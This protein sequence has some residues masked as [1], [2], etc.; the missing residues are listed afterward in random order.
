MRRKSLGDCEKS[1]IF[2][3]DLCRKG[4]DKWVQSGAPPPDG[5]LNNSKTKCT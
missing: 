1:R 2:A 5:T 3:A 4:S